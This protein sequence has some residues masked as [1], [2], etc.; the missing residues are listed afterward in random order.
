MKYTGET[1]EARAGQIAVVQKRTSL[2]E[3]TLDVIWTGDGQQ[4]TIEASDFTLAYPGVQQTPVPTPTQPTV[5]TVDSV[6]KTKR[7][8]YDC[9]SSTYRSLIS[10]KF[11]RDLSCPL[12]SI[13]IAKVEAYQFE[14][15]NY[16]CAGHPKIRQLLTGD[17]EPPLLSY[18]PY[19][20]YKRK[21]VAPAEY[22]FDYSTADADIKRMRES[23]KETLADECDMI[24]DNPPALDGFRPCNNAVFYAL[25]KSLKVSH[26][27]ILRNIQHGDGIALIRCGMP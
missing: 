19:L 17:F 5:T 22:V 12:D 10:V 8:V 2:E 24:L 18:K 4:A 27:H 21:E 16:L 25:R 9:S 6:Y 3:S 14:I 23:G 26:A 11:P 13:D 15:D 7:P 20:A 1:A